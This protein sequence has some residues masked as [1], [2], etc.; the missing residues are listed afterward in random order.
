MFEQM[1][2]GWF[3]APITEKARRF[4]LGSPLRLAEA[5][6]ARFLGERGID[7]HWHTDDFEPHNF[8]VGAWNVTIAALTEGVEE[9]EAVAEWT[10]F[11]R[12]LPEPTNLVVILGGTS[13]QPGPIPAHNILTAA[14]WLR[15]FPSHWTPYQEAAT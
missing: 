12:V 13:R 15:S 6:F 1:E 11:V 9:V 7:Y 8:T 10:M 5:A 3:V 4:A 2:R 14:E